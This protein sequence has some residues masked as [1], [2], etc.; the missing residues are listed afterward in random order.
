MSNFEELA[1]DGNI[2]KVL[3]EIGYETP[4]PIQERTIPKV[5]SGSDIIASAQTGSGK[6]AAFMLP[7]LHLLGQPGYRTKQGPQILVLVPTRELA[8]QVAEEAKKFSKYLPKTKTVCI[9]GGIPYPIQKRAL[10]S[11]Y[12]IL[13]ATPGRLLDHVERGRINLSSV[14]LLVLDRPIGCLTWVLLAM[15]KKSQP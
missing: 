9:Y 6:T 3:K 15:W 11:K 5:L 7:G 8:M 4:T 10:A 2:L 14:K 13:V 12:E 1:L